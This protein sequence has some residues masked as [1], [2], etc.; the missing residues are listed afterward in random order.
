M[1]SKNFPP[2]LKNSNSDA[3]AG[4]VGWLQR[5]WDLVTCTGFFQHIGDVEVGE[6]WNLDFEEGADVFSACL[7][8]LIRSSFHVTKALASVGLSEGKEPRFMS[9]SLTTF[10]TLPNLAVRAF[11]SCCCFFF[12]TGLGNTL[13]LI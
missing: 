6:L 10:L 4:V 11:L 5:L 7:P 2:L 12:S 13:E 9:M 3:R 1:G 8:S